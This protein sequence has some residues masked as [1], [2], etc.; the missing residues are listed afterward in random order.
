MSRPDKM[1]RV[2]IWGGAGSRVH[3]ARQHYAPDD[4][5]FELLVRVELKNGFLVNL[6]EVAKGEGWG[7]DHTFDDRIGGRA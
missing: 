1:I 6:R 5:N 3:V 7:P 4:P 2:D